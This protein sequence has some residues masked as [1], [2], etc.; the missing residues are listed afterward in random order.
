MDG[1]LTLF[2]QDY[3]NEVN[4]QDA[5]KM[6]NPAENLGM[7]RDG[8]TLIVERRE[9]ITNPDSIF[10]KLWNTRIISY[11]LELSSK[12]FEGSGINA[13]L[14]DKYLSKEIHLSLAGDDHYDFSVTS[15][16]ASRREDRFMVIFRPTVGESVMP[17]NFL[18]CSVSSTQNGIAMNWKTANEQ[19]VKYFTIERSS[20][21][22][23]FESTGLTVS[24]MNTIT[25]EYR[26]VDKSPMAGYSYY[27]VCA[28]DM[29]GR[30]TYSKVMKTAAIL[31]ARLTVYPNPA[32]TSNIQ[33]SIS[34]HQAGQYRI[35]LIGGFG[36]VLHSQTGQLSAGIS[37][38]RIMT[39]QSLP[40]GL[41][42]VEV[43][44]PAGYKVV[45][46]LLINN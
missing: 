20:D 11:R 38:I 10:F 1:T 6:F 44:D 2:H 45:Q 7:L 22:V 31:N 34:G 43:T 36:R 27:R 15:D 35:S 33:V 4:Q 26:V 8:R 23:N 19:N 3:S 9:D 17:L 13:V 16:A 28:H 46:N 40:N 39:S 18:A 12:N 5:R 24:A 32:T 21:G 14:L 25:N 30:L 37:N 29:D 41:Y 42:Q